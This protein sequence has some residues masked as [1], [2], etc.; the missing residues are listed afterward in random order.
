MPQLYAVARVSKS[1][2]MKGEKASV[3]VGVRVTLSAKWRFGHAGM[4]RFEV[5]LSDSPVQRQRK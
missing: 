3:L 2:K 1:S 5:L 4:I